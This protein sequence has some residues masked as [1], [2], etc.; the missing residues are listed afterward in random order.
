LF[1]KGGDVGPDLTS[2]QRQDVNALLNAIAN[3]SEEIREGY[4]NQTI[5]TRDGRTL[6][7]F[8]AEQDE[9]VI[10]LRGLDGSTK[11]IPVSEIVSR[12][13]AGASLM[14][15]GLLN[16]FEPQEVRDLV[17]YLQMTQPLVLKRN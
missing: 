13:S 3:P 1:E 7:G 5:V 4:E 6:V 11:H 8:L 2:Y 10:T 9:K 17:A 16:R 15:E 12:Q 14:P